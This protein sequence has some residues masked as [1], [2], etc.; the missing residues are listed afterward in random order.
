MTNAL[1][2]ST[3][4]RKSPKPMEIGKKAH[5]HAPYQTSKSKN[6]HKMLKHT[7]YLDSAVLLEK[8]GSYKE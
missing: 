1:H 7:F 4:L 3:G 5:M 2:L 8:N 6:P